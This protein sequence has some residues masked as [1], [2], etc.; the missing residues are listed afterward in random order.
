MTNDFWTRS[1]QNTLIY[2]CLVEQ[3]FASAFDLVKY[4]IY[5]SLYFA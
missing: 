4:K 3:L 2:L 1:S 5:K